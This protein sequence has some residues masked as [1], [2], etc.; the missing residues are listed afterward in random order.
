M[1]KKVEIKEIV[2]ELSTKCHFST[3]T[4][5]L[6]LPHYTESLQNISVPPQRDTFKGR[7]KITV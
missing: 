5:T 6:T 2:S 1:Q 7:Y 4:G 3:S